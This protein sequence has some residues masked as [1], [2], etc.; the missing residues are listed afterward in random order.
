MKKS[1]GI[2]VLLSIFFPGA[3]SLYCDEIL[4]GILLMMFTTIGYFCFIIPGI[5]LHIIA[6]VTAYNDAN[7]VNKRSWGV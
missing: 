1:P 6:I 3:G 4:T 2:A 5:I 7:R